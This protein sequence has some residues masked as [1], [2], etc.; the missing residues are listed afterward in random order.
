LLS[1]A[2]SPVLLNSG[3]VLLSNSAIILPSS[4]W[5]NS[6]V[7]GTK[8]RTGPGLPP[9]VEGTAVSRADPRPM[10]SVEPGAVL[11]GGSIYTCKPFWPAAP[12][13]R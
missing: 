6:P 11:R 2:A 9:S 7:A 5:K 8:G 4:L 13:L 12:D 1:V 10:V 3:L